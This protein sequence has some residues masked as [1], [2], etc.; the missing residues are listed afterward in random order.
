[1]RT[2]TTATLTAVLVAG[3][4]ALGGCG[5]DGDAAAPIPTTGGGSPAAGA[6]LAD[7]G[8]GVVEA[9]AAEGAGIVA[10]RAYLFVA[11]DG[12]AR[13]CD[14][15]RESFPPQCGGAAMAVTGLPPEMLDALPVD[16]GRRWSDG[17]VQLLGTVRDG[18][19]VND[20]AALAA[21]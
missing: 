21:G 8:L 18:V 10:V 20:P 15:V 4:L 11:A 2:G 7:G 12:A 14:A 13:L 5:G 6:M 1:M 16:G 9:R 19:F 17:P 3:A